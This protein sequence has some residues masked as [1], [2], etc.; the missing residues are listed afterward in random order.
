MGEENLPGGAVAVL[1]SDRPSKHFRR[2]RTCAMRRREVASHLRVDRRARPHSCRVRS[3]Q[4]VETT[5][6]Q[7]GREK[8]PPARV[9]GRTSGEPNFR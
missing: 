6:R 5:P 3:G 2:S 8:I 7:L 9:L 4:S 1:F